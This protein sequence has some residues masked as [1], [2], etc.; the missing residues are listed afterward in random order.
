MNVERG[1]KML[2]LLLERFKF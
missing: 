2:F 1:M